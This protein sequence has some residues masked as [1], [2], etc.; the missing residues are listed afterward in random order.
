[1]KARS[2]GFRPP[3]QKLAINLANLQTTL[4]YFASNTNNN[5]N[6]N[7]YYNHNN[8]LPQMHLHT[9]AARVW[10]I[11]IIGKRKD[12][13]NTFKIIETIEDGQEVFRGSADHYPV[14]SL[15]IDWE[16][17]QHS[18]IRY[19]SNGTVQHQ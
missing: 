4:P 9:E 19:A 8:N 5:N 10:M 2:N 18:T 15:R 14:F 11:N 7:N 3:N 13:H 12:A 16:V 6:N 17:Q 1:M